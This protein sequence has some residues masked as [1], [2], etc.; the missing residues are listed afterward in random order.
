MKPDCNDPVHVVC[1]IVAGFFLTMIG[2]LIQL[3][4]SDTAII[5]SI[6]LM[7][8]GFIWTWSGLARF[9]Y[10]IRRKNYQLIEV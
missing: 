4:Q 9:M 5:I 7:S 10:I 2:L 6:I 3:I 1:L 8:I